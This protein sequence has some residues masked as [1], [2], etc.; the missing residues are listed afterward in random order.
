LNTVSLFTGAGGLDY[1]F[2]A[3]GF[4]TRVAVEIDSDCCKTIQH[5]CNWPIINKDVHNVTTEEI[6]SVGN[7]KKKEVDLLLGGPPC[8]PFSKS[9]YWANGSTKRLDDPRADTLHAYM[10]CVNEI[11]P[12]VFVIENVH[13]INYSG[14]G[15]GFLL[16][17]SLTR[18]INNKRGTK[19]QLSWKVMNVADYGVP[20][21][22]KRFFLVG[23]RDGQVFR[24]PDPTHRAFLDNNDLTDEG[25]NYVQLIAD[26]VD[27]NLPFHVTAWDAIG[28][29][30]LDP[31]EDLRVSG[32]W[33]DLLSSIPEGENYLWHTNR[34]EGLPL[35]GWRT[36][37][38][39]FLLKLAKNRPAWTIVAQPGPATGP[40]HWDNRL[41]S[42]KELARLQTFPDDIIV[43]GS[44]RSAQMQI[45]NA[46]PS[47]I[48]EILARAIVEQSWGVTYDL[49]LK[50]KV[51]LQRPIPSPEE[52]ETV[53]QKYLHLVGNYADHPGTGKGPRANKEN[54]ELPLASEDELQ[55]TS[56]IKKGREVIQQRFVME[57]N[58]AR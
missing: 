54:V 30:S 16:L 46:V 25:V 3:A 4:Q 21:L 56:R 31:D 40:F 49:P 28:Q 10:R 11:L 9:A 42:I 34:K 24:F 17:E 39:N 23:H 52:I 1:G 43:V 48:G 20:Q 55:D 41:L 33:A 14:K 45:G 53:P 22:R 12:K 19:Y 37:F 6:L 32:K 47:L 50:F 26:Y 35:F 44:R 18:E 15:D 51:N 13:G 58:T 36:R 57:R 38:W 29:L 8:Q 5:N 2:E 7:F 27:P